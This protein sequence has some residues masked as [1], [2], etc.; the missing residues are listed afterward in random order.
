MAK[1]NNEKSARDLLDLTV[2]AQR[3]ARPGWLERWLNW[4]ER[5]AENLRVDAGRQLCRDGKHDFVGWEKINTIQIMANQTDRIPKGH[6]YVFL[7]RC[8]RCNLP[9]MKT[10]HDYQ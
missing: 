2:K 10:L 6:R 7:G 5:E 9:E 1:L 4:K 3:L 8:V